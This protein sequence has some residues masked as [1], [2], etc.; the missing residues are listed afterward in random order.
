MKVILNKILFLLTIALMV[1][2]C[3]DDDQI[4]INPNAETIATLSTN[5]VVLD[6]DEEGKDVLTVTWTEP[7]FGYPA[8]ANYKIYFNKA[9]GDIADAES[10]N[11]GTSF[12]KTFKSEELNKI[13]L[14][15]ELEPKEAADVT[16]VVA[17]ILNDKTGYGILSDPNTLKATPYADLLDLS[18]PWGLV[19]SA[20]NNWGATPDAP[21]YKTDEAG[22]YVAYVTLLTGEWKIRKDNSWDVNYGDTG[23]NGT[24]EKGG[25]NIKS[26][27]GTYK[28]VFNENT[29]TY[30]VTPYTIGLVGSATANGWDGPDMPLS[31]DSYSD[32]WRGQFKLKEGEIKFRL[33][34]DWGVNYGDDGK[35]GTLESGGP[36]IPVT[37]GYYDVVLD[38]NDLT[39]TLEKTLVY[40]VVGS[41]YNEW[42][43]TPDYP[44][45]PDY[46]EEGV[47]YIKS[48]TLLDGEIKF[49]AN[50]DWAVNYGDTGNDGTLEADG[51]NIPSKAGNYRIRMDLSDP[52]KMTYTITKN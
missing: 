19:G 16:V 10:V 14:N 24:L 47:Y 5:Q 44:F 36:N 26:T 12:S 18:T 1:G 42:G 6:K 31:Y 7:D 34:N 39:Y 49:R 13:L 33:N 9:G 4:V 40:G 30:T 46:S 3:S 22:V 2:S 17:A 50:N 43:A 28:I 45:T 37:A 52:D 29:L 35:N 20:Y 27:A 15:L 11:G 51:T 32:T 38:L 25:D 23:A 48:I 41:G 8:A 21:F